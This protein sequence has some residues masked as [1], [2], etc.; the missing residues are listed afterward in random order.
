M[1][2]PY[3]Q[4]LLN[5]LGSHGH[6]EGMQNYFVRD[7]VG[8]SWAMVLQFCMHTHL[9]EQVNTTYLSINTLLNKLNVR[10][11]GR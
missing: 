2:K 3:S 10:L 9:F 11:E 1:P 4:K 5:V 8:H 7:K 6:F